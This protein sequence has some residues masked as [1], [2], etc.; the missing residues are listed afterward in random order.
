MKLNM[1][2]SNLVQLLKEIENPIQYDYNELQNEIVRLKI[3]NKSTMQI[4]LDRESKLKKHF[5]TGFNAI[6]SS[7][8]GD[9]NS[10]RMEKEYIKELRWSIFKN[11]QRILALRDQKKIALRKQSKSN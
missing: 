1:V 2:N 3:I 11:G 9:T 10:E 5:D 8:Y 7:M 4:V 6:I